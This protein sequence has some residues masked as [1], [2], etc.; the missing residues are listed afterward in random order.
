MKP[1]LITFRDTFAFALSLAVLA[2]STAFSQNGTGEST[3]LTPETKR[4]SYWPSQRE[5]LELID[6]SPV[7]IQRW[8]RT[9]DEAARRLFWAEVFD[10]SKLDEIAKAYPSLTEADL[11]STRNSVREYVAFISRT[12][13]ANRVVADDRLKEL[14]ETYKKLGFA[15]MPGLLF[16]GG[17]EKPGTFEVSIPVATS[18]EYV[19]IVATDTI[20]G[21]GVPIALTA[22]SETNVIEGENPKANPISV[23]GLLW[24]PGKN[25]LSTV[26]LDFKQSSVFEEGLRCQ[27]SATVGRR[28][29]QPD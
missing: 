18:H 23:A 4:Y 2:I 29:T 11:I 13:Y 14:V 21:I 22:I 16:Q 17:A 27:W 12:R 3:V 28:P 20:A 26:V 5:A 8:V 19:F 1:F 15:F 10:N 7:S 6:V 9:Q 24:S 25:G